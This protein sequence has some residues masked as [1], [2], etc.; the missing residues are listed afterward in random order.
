MNHQPV[1]ITGALR[2]LKHHYDCVFLTSFESLFNG[3]TSANNRFQPSFT[4]LPLYQMGCC[5][6]AS[7][8][9]FVSTA[10]GLV[11]QNNAP[12][13]CRMCHVLESANAVLALRRRTATS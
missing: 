7:P 3:Q 8:L 12:S 11:L 13:Q 6:S 5:L 1:T 9:L 2:V 4:N 10:H